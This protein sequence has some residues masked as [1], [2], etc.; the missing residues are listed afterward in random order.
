MCDLLGGVRG[1]GRAKPSHGVL[2]CL[3]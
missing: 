1:R 3:S 2:P